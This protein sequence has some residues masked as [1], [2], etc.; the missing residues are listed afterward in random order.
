MFFIDSV[1]KKNLYTLL[2]YHRQTNYAAVNVG[3]W[4]VNAMVKL[5]LKNENNFLMQIDA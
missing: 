4:N 1:E 5:P 3:S 2:A